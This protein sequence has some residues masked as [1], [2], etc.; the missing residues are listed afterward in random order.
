[1]SAKDQS[2]LKL[3]KFVLENTL[4]MDCKNAEIN[5]LAS[6]LQ[7]DLKAFA[8]DTLAT[9]L[10][11]LIKLNPSVL[12]LV[13]SQFVLPL[14]INCEMP[15]DKNVHA[16]YRLNGLSFYEFE[17]L[18]KMGAIKAGK[19]FQR[20]LDAYK[21]VI[22]SENKLMIFEQK[23]ALFH[24]YLH[25][26]HADNLDSK[27]HNQAP[28][29]KNNIFGFATHDVVYSCQA[30]VFRLNYSR[31]MSLTKDYSN[32]QSELYN[33]WINSCK[34]CL[35]ARFNIEGYD[36]LASQQVLMGQ[37]RANASLCEKMYAEIPNYSL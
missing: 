33:S 19:I 24:E 34:T 17:I 27:A 7:V 37:K 23:S 32:L 12:N 14:K 28:K 5:N 10:L 31:I 25:Y 36:S 30:T 15:K 4:V 26:L 16:S 29:G 22:V 3:Y 8:I 21:N 1:M 20:Y 2:S 11:E 18:E 13:K 35:N 9:G 6:T